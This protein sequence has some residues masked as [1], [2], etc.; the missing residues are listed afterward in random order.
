MDSW[1][2]FEAGAGLPRRTVT[3]GALPPQRQPTGHSQ[4]RATVLVAGPD[5]AATE[6]LHTTLAGRGRT[7]GPA[8]RV[9]GRRP[10][11]P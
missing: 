4:C 2:I 11:P 5:D 1:C 9:G 10:G 7:V 3:D 6:T 8:G